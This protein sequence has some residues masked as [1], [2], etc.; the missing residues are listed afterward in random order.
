MEINQIKR[1]QTLNLKQL[2]DKKKA[3]QLYTLWS[4]FLSL[5]LTHTHTHTEG[6]QLTCPHFL[7]PY[8][9]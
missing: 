8:V 1:R 4:G 7:V 5:S 9:V 6:F 2:Y 3:L